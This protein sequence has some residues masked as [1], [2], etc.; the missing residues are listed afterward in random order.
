MNN[1]DL[2]AAVT[3]GEDEYQQPLLS[4]ERRLQHV[5]TRAKLTGIMDRLLSEHKGGEGTESLRIVREQ[6]ARFGNVNSYWLYTLVHARSDGPQP[7][8]PILIYL[9]Y[10]VTVV[11]GSLWFIEPR[12]DELDTLKA[13][14]T[15]LKDVVQLLGLAVFLLLAFRNNSS[16]ARWMDGNAKFNQLTSNVADAGRLIYTIAP[17]KIAFNMLWWLFS[18]FYSA[19]M[20]LRFAAKEADWSLLEEALPAEIWAKISRKHDKF[21]W[22]LFEFGAIA[23]ATDVEGKTASKGAE[24]IMK[25][26]PPIHSIYSACKSIVNTPMPPAYLVHLRSFLLLWLGILPFLFI[27]SFGYW[28]VPLCGII[29]WAILGVEEAACEIEN[30]FG[31]DSND[32]P[33]DSIAKDTIAELFEY[34]VLCEER[35][36][37]AGVEHTRQ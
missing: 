27:T 29:A 6:P 36:T 33:L 13:M 21:R 18:T 5:H 2:E 9:V 37:G 7:Y 19:K 15:D 23:A 30:C 10:T 4:A 26:V 28:S 20:Q 25:A 8:V 3:N 32:L 24:D 14:K 16:Y 34:I 31:F 12:F 35:I 17:P 11:L 22:S 1:G